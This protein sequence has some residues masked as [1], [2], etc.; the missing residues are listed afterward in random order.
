[1][2]NDWGRFILQAKKASSAGNYAYAE[3]IWTAALQEAEDFG[4]SDERLVQTLEGLADAY[5]KQ[6]KY[7]H[8]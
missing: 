3:T 5:T 8:A 4:E 7:R 2:D 1:M 6:G